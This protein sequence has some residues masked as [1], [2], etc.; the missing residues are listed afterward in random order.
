MTDL[1]GRCI[2]ITGA[3]SGLGEALAL[4]ASRR[5]ARLVLSARRAAELERVRAACAEPAQVAVLPLDLLDFDPAAALR[6]AESHFGTIDVLVNNAGISHRSTVIETGMTVYRQL[7]ELDFFAPLALSKAML[8]GMQARG[9]GHVLTISSV[10]GKIGAPQRSGY[11]AAK[12][13]LHG[14]IDAARAELAG[15]GV[16]FTT[17]CPG[18]IRT[19]F[20]THAVL[21]DGSVYGKMDRGQLRGM[22]PQR[23]AD[24]IWRAVERNR[25][26][27]YLGRERITIYLQRWV[28][29]LVRAVLKRYGHPNRSASP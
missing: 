3:S 16:G 7:F 19:P 23:C 4:S 1:K 13:A 12:H 11:S 10:V 8:P 22:D 14:F 2:W 17:V 9:R 29:S 6:E 18:Y 21:G 27:I 28:P 15:D 5:G 24:I 25:D 20:S 26:E